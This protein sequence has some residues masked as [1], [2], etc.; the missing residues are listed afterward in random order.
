[1]THSTKTH[2]QTRQISASIHVRTGIVCFFPAAKNRRISNASSGDWAGH[3]KN[4]HRN[5]HTY[6]HTSP[7]TRIH[8]CEP[9]HAEYTCLTFSKRCPRPQGHHC[10]PVAPILGPRSRRNPTC[11]FAYPHLIFQ[12]PE[13]GC[14]TASFVQ[15]RINIIICIK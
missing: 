2:E 3:T 1:M 7:R 9:A 5:T 6:I 4:I 15:R 8:V 13:R 14:S 10:V 12:P 11:T